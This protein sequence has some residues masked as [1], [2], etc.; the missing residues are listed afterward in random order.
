MG[1]FTKKKFLFK[2][3][4]KRK[5]DMIFVQETKLEDIDRFDVQKLWGN[6]NFEFA[7]SKS[8]GASGGLL[9]IWNKEFLRATSIIIHRSFILVEGVINNAFP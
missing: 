4:K 7:Y 6:G 5:P 2:L 8:N 1:S 9:S 3:I